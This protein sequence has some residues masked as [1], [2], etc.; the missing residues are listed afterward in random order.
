[1]LAQ[2]GCCTAHSAPCSDQPWTCS[3]PLHGSVSCKCLPVLLLLLVQ[4]VLYGLTHGGRVLIADEMGVGKTVQALALASCYQV[5]GDDLATQEGWDVLLSVACCCYAFIWA[6]SVSPS[7]HHDRSCSALERVRVFVLQTNACLQ[8]EWP[9]L[10]IVPASLRL[11]WAEEIER[12][13]PHVRPGGVT[14]IEGKED[15]YV[16]LWWLSCCA[17]CVMVVLY[18]CCA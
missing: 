4:G 7:C 18:G 15:R 10:I 13:L 11:V 17:W 1:M 14:V 12:W 8:E 6:G 2:S 3:A 9:L 5:R 16:W